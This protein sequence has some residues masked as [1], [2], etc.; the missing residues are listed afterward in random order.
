MQDITHRRVLNIALPILVSNAT[1]PLLG[2]VDTAVVGQMGAAAPIGAV[3][4]GGIILSTVYMLFTFLRMGTSGLTAQAHGRGSPRETALVL[5]RALL[6]AVLGGAGLILLHLP[7][8]TGAFALSPASAEVEDL[9]RSYVSIRIWGAPAT[10]A[11]YAITGWLIAL[12]RAR[13]VLMLQLWINVINIALDVLFVIVLGL[14]VPGVA[15]A[16]LIGEWAGLAL[17]L[18]LCR[19]AFLPALRS[20]WAEVS[21]RVAVRHTM[22]MN[23]DLV[24]RSL[25]LQASYTSFVFLSAGQG[26]VSLAANQVLLQF[27]HLFSYLLDA[28]AFSAEALVGQAVGARRVG[29]LRR[30]AALSGKWA[31]AGSLLLAAAAILGGPQ[32]IA[33]MTTSPE[34]RA[35]AGKYLAWVWIMPLASFGSFIFDGIFIGAT[36]SRQM[37][38]VMFL[39]LVL[40]LGTILATLPFLGNHA[41]WLGLVVMS[42]ART[43]LM[44]HSYPRAEDKARVL[45]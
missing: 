21:E 20:T 15:A 43:V 6:I 2:L 38:N 42:V 33:A 40:Y 35:E 14:G 7:I 27:L 13:S 32:M 8:L 16:T 31:F 4:L 12:E 11:I 17:A 44:A 36:L 24:L 23:A 45:P 41:L 25:L 26:D 3:G 39:S 22:A 30:A 28:F 5:H 34:V 37:R 18:W 9:A 10:I 1:I 19:E 29:A